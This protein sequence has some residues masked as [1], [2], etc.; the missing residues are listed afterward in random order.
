MRRCKGRACCEL[1]SLTTAG[2]MKLQPMLALRAMSG[3]ISL[4]LILQ[5]QTMKASLIGVATW[6]HVDV[7][8]LW[9]TGPAPHWLLALWRD[10]ATSHLLPC[11]LPRQHSGAGRLAWHECR[12]ASLEGMRVGELT[13]P[14][15]SEALDELTGTVLD[16]S[17]WWSGYGIAGRMTKTA[18]T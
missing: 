13:L 8:G 11:N 5:L 12:W 4:W 2:V 15:A 17:P 3:L 6:N 16:G 7:Q 14:P 9:R 1:P 10:G 18:T